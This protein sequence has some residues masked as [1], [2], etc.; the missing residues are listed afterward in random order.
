MESI[1]GLSENFR[2]IFSFSFLS[3]LSFFSKT[4]TDLR[5]AL[6]SS[7]SSRPS[8]A[9][10][11]MV[12]SHR[13]KVKSNQRKE[14][15]KKNE[16]GVFFGFRFLSEKKER[17]RSKIWHRWWEK[18]GKGGKEEKI[19]GGEEREGPPRR[20]VR[21]LFMSSRGQPS[22]PTHPH[23]FFTRNVVLLLDA[24]QEVEQKCQ[25]LRGRRSR[26]TESREDPEWRQERL[27]L[28]IVLH[29]Y[30]DCH[31]RGGVGVHKNQESRIKNKNKNK[32]KRERKK[33]KSNRRKRKKK[34]KEKVNRKKKGTKEPGP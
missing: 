28:S 3:F 29:R 34:E 22:S 33:E 15:K 9:K 19:R 2:F 10:K 14:K 23:E 4:E 8:E 7:L 24:R 13:T 11:D 17:K 25:H 5:R 6:L 26:G 21:R 20:S 31:H 32:N 12:G 18:Q 1:K 27:P 16:E 30:F